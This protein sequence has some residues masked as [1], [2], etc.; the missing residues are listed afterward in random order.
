MSILLVCRLVQV[1]CRLC[2]S[3]SRI[4]PENVIVSRLRFVENIDP[5]PSLLNFVLLLLSK[6]NHVKF[7]LQAL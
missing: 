4:V 2:R 3:I 5:R 1:L 7:T 6:R